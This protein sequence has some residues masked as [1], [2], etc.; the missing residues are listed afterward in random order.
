M[1]FQVHPSLSGNNRSTATMIDEDL[2]LPAD[3]SDFVAVRRTSSAFPRR[4]GTDSVSFRWPRTT[5]L[6]DRPERIRL[7]NVEG[8]RSPSSTN[9][10]VRS[11]LDHFDIQTVSF[12]AE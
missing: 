11:S 1:V 10:S 12:R 7:V 2:R 6:F 5:V 9:Q 8:N 4:S 3:T